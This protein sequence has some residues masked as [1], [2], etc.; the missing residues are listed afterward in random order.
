MIIGAEAEGHACYRCGKLTSE[1]AHVSS[2][3]EQEIWLCS[4]ECMRETMIS[5]LK[6]APPH[7][8]K[9]IREMLDKL[10]RSEWET[11]V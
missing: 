6:N 9:R 7:R 10:A 3:S 5:F 2:T 11:D 8:A 1:I 4:P